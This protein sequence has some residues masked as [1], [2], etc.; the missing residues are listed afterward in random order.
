[1]RRG[2]PRSVA[3][4]A[5]CAG[6]LTSVAGCGNM[7]A[8]K[9]AAPATSAASSTAAAKPQKLVI[10]AAEGYDQAMATAFQKATGITV[11]LEDMSTGPLIAKVEAEKNNPRWDVVW[12]D[13]DGPM[14]TLDQ[15]GLLLEH[16]QPANT[17]NYTSLGKQLESPDGSYIPTGV[18]AAGAIAYNTHLVPKAD[19]PTHWSDLLK[20]FFKNS[21]GM[22][23]PSISGPTFPVVAGFLYKMGLTKGEH[24]FS[25]LKANGLKVYPTNKP[26]LQALSTGVIKV[27][28]AQDSAEIQAMQTG[29]PIKIVYPA[30]GVTMLPGALG[31]DI[32]APDMAAAKEFANFVLSAQ[33][34][35][36]M[37]AKGGGDS[38]F[39]PVV[40]G[41]NPN[42]TRQ[43][44][45][46]T[47][48]KVPVAWQ[49]KNYNTILTWFQDSIVG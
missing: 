37:L 34:Q 27:A 40:Q 19:V 25:Q 24:F 18:T 12:F 49:A 32:H 26:T 21:V 43:Q 47:W 8:S 28:V 41:E 38:N 10:Y 46:I 9:P 44:T 33:G 4:V 22:D 14:Y 35:Q 17:T 5:L 39:N 30:G 3:A 2:L 29:A 6:M 15:E 20:P 1:M 45:G 31:I 7:S 36:I 23:N 42:P 16:W 11:K 48:N 13:G